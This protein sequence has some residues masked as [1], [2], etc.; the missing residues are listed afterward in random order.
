MFGAASLPFT[1]AGAYLPAGGQAVV[2]NF[3]APESTAP[4]TIAPTKDYFLRNGR[5]FFYLADTVWS[6]F[7]NPTFEEWEYYL[8]FRRSQG[9]NALQINILPQGDR[10]KSATDNPM[11]FMRTSEGKEDF[12]RPN[13]AYFSRAAR[14]TAMAVEKGFVPA[15]VLMWGNLVPGTWINTNYNTQAMQMEQVRPYVK[16]V[17]DTFAK[18][19]PIWIVSGDSDLPDK[20]KAWFKIARDYLKE[21]TPHLLC[22]FHLDS[23]AP[24]P[25]YWTDIYLTYSG[26]SIQNEAT[27]YKQAIDRWSRK[28]K[29][30]VLNGE[31]CY[32]AHGS[33]P[34]FRFSE[35]DVRR[36][37][38][39]SFL[40]GAKAGIAYGGHGVWCWHRTGQK[41]GNEKWAQLPL[42]WR[43]AIKLQG[44]WDMGFA[45]S[46]FEQYRL[47]ELNPHQELLQVPSE[48]VRMAAKDDLTT[49][50]VYVPYPREIKIKT[51]LSGYEIRMINLVTRAFETPAV[52]FGKESTIAMSESNAD[53]LIVGTR[54]NA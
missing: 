50:A 54:K 33:G 49:F 13:P 4:V 39:W 38:W 31:P 32:E 23:K 47:Y 3:P 40:S 44:S 10:S 43:N 51:D 34:D 28:T 20:G 8:N 27:A 42:D 14:L 6:A 2:T 21:L 25:E 46:L 19:N 41:F 24:L 1:S 52:F 17:V 37:A 12:G 16:Y 11:P 15:L 9:F 48:H 35:F 22:T 18:F 5:Y 7:T 29:H 36:Q 53:V 45:R 26:H 30:P